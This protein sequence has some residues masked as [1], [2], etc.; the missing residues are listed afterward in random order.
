MSSIQRNSV[1]VLKYIVS[2]KMDEETQDNLVTDGIE[3][4]EVAEETEA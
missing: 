3:I 4:E 1:E 2:Y